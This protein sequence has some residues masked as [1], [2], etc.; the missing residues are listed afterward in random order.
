MA[1]RELAETAPSEVN[2]KAVVSLAP[3][4]PNDTESVVPDGADDAPQCADSVLE[5]SQVPAYLVINGSHDGDTGADG[6]GFY[7]RAGTEFA[8]PPDGLTK[9]MVWIYRRRHNGFV[10]PP[11]FTEEVGIL[12]DPES[13]SDETHHM[14]LKAYANGFL[15]W[16]LKNHWHYRDLF[17]GAARSP[18][19]Q[20]VADDNGD[21]EVKVYLQYSEGGGA[22]RRVIDNFECP[23]SCG[24]PGEPQCWEISTLGEEVIKVG[25]NSVA[26]EI[27]LENHDTEYEKHR[28]RAL[29]MRWDEVAPIDVPRLHFNVPQGVDEVNGW[30]DQSRTP[31]GEMNDVRFFTHLSFRVGQVP[32]ALLNTIPDEPLNGDPFD[33]ASLQ[34]LDFNVE[35]EDLYGVT[36]RVK[37]SEVGDLYTPLSGEANPYIGEIAYPVGPELILNGTP[38]EQVFAHLQTIRIPI[39]AFCDVDLTRLKRVSIELDEDSDTLPDGTRHFRGFFV[40]DSLEFVAERASFHCELKPNRSTEPKTK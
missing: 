34:P 15:R 20:E 14:L 10:A 25:D 21:G 6:F 19:V 28:T 26:A 30:G 5:G 37:V 8:P 36:Q 16:H 27:R 40:L 1:A 33:P 4:I 39:T 2:L 31:G 22:R 9:S 18:K 11:I 35:L 3:D 17:S 29:F 32:D 23:E 12:P 38:V 7:D 24:G 13:L